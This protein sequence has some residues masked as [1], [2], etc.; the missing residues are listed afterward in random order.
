MAFQNMGTF[1]SGVIT[2]PGN[3]LGVMDVAPGAAT[4]GAFLESELEKRDTMIRK[5]LTSVTYPRDIEIDVGGGWADFVSAMGV[6]YGVSGGS[7][8][9][10]VTAGGA[11][12]IPI[13]QASV[14]KGLFKAH[15]FQVALRIMYQDMQRANFIGRSLDSLLTDGV[16]YAYDMHVE[17]NVYEGIAEYNT[18][19]LLN[20]AEVTATTV[21]AGAATTTTWST[22]TPDEIL[23]DVNDA[24]ATV[25]GAAGYDLDAI[26][27][28]ILIPYEQFSYI[29]T[30]PV[31]A[32]ATESILDYIQKNNI[33]AKNG[34][35]L[36]IG[37]TKWNKGIGVGGTDRM[38]VYV[39]KRR[40]LKMDELVPLTRAMYLANAT[41][42]A[43][44]TSYVANISEP[45]VM[46]TQTIMY[47]DG[48]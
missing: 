37:A 43:Y 11:N 16:R 4:G 34:V 24:L 17:Q 1:N 39:N 19:G 20:N 28:H 6:S 8:A 13:V 27:N 48:I 45:E 23:K 22:K 32:L 7:G 46:Y 18:T 31:S 14:D 41:E 2:S 40:Y 3:S 44:D 25:W 21:A 5:P 47:F 15:A 10:P 9:A 12:A 29:L 36:F 42:N 26:P 38:V 33:A 35:D 30:N